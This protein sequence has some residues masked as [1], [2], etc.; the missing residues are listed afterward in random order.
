MT[1]LKGEK[2]K[3]KWGEITEKYHLY[4]TINEDT[5][6]LNKSLAKQWIIIAIKPKTAK[7]I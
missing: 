4:Y 3:G 6:A 5:A 7:T 1:I 2:R